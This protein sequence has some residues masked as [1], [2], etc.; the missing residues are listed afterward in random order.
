[1]KQKL[2]SG[3][4]KFLFGSILVILFISLLPLLLEIGLCYWAYKKISDPQRKWITIA[5][6]S[7]FL[8]PFSIAWIIGLNTP[9]R[10]KPVSH[11]TTVIPAKNTSSPIVS[12]QILTI[13][14][15]KP[16]LSPSPTPKPSIT[17][18]K[19][20]STPKPTFTPAP[21]VSK[22]PV[23]NTTSSSSS[24]GDKDCSDFSSHAQA[25]EY[26]TSHGGSPTNNY[27]RLDNNHDGVACEDLP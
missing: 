12:P 24:S 6:I 25:Q 10:P 2:F 7:I 15:P 23:Q 20:L 26:F 18:K 22:P 13:Q 4:R 14:T 1:M 5:L 8:V 16:V 19:V 27:D 21:A 11:D 17:P 3:K 9:E